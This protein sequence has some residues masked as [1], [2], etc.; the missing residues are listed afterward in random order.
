M[1]NTYLCRRVREHGTYG[2]RESVKAKYIEIEKLF[3]NKKPRTICRITEIGIE[4]MGNYIEA[5]KDY[6]K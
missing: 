6:I 5:L 2:L 3:E 1:H 4:A